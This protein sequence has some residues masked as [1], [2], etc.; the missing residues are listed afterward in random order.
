MATAFK[1]GAAVVAFESS[2]GP[3]V[4]A[5]SPLRQARRLVQSA[6]LLEKIAPLG[7]D[8]PG[9]RP[10]ER[11]PDLRDVYIISGRR[12]PGDPPPADSRP[13]RAGRRDD[14]APDGGRAPRTERMG[15]ARIVRRP[16]SASLE[17]ARLFA[18]EHELAVRLQ[19]SLL[20]DRLP[21]ADGVELDGHYLA[22]GDAVE[23]GGD[24]YDAVRR[25]DGIIQLCV[26]DV[27]GKGIGAATVMGRQRNVFHVYARDY[28]SPA[29]I[30]RRMLRHVTGEEMI[31]LACVSFDPY[32]G[33]L[34]YSCAGHPPPLLVDRRTG[35]VV[36]LD[37]ASAPPIGV[38]E[39]G[40]I[41]EATV[42]STQD[43]VL[44]MYTD[45]LIERRG[46]NIDEGID[47]LGRVV[48]SS[49]DVTPDRIVRNVSEA[50]GAPDDDVALLLLTIEDT[51]LGFEVEVPAE[52]ST[53]PE[54]RRRLR[55]WLERQQVGAAEAAD[56]VLAVSEACNNAIEH[57]YRDREG[58]IKLRLDVE[59]NAVR[60][61]IEDKG[62]WL[63]ATESGGEGGRGIAL[64]KHLTHSAEIESDANGTR[65]ALVLHLRAGDEST[66]VGAPATPG[67]RSLAR[68][69]RSGTFASSTVIQMPR[70]TLTEPTFDLNAVQLAETLVVEVA[71][72]IDMATAP[73]LAQALAAD[74]LHDSVQR[75]VVDLTAVTF[76]DS[77]AL[78][79]LVQ[80]QRA[81]AAREI[82]FRVVSPI[83]EAVR[84][85]FEITQLADQLR[86]VDSRD[87]ALA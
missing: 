22:G 33:E 71:G 37:Q 49:A 1:H 16:G 78:N 67:P 43:A 20:P 14:F 57:A 84:R 55:G 41:I 25:D 34:S 9:S 23:V 38:A 51:H 87:D 18:H 60:A 24:W 66:L 6:S 4:K 13:G 81:L 32:T 3:Q 35:V 80:S 70:P 5:V 54:L 86:V 27:S 82:A 68:S 28:V 8:G 45:G 40:D 48:A 2:D 42:A 11:D 73:E 77:S 7:T 75:V 52:P 72:E 21:T 19:R 63:E 53:L 10:I 64:M 46:Q 83:D 29:E 44:A 36:R 85:I 79:A 17:R 26:G 50:L 47:L 61:L 59:P 74:V 39:P 12:L 76:L 69:Q 58:T 62:T 30:V 31:T 65:V 15:P 56:V